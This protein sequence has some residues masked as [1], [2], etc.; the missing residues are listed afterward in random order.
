MDPFTEKM[1]KFWNLDQLDS[2]LSISLTLCNLVKF[3]AT[4]YE[5]HFQ[6]FL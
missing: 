4:C 3:N 2:R 1:I 5:K 6:N